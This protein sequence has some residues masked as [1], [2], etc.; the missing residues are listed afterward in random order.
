MF[1][2]VLM[3]G[4]TEVSQSFISQRRSPVDSGLRRSL[5]PHQ[6]RISSV[7]TGYDHP[8]ASSLNWRSLPTELSANVFARDQRVTPVPVLKLLLPLPQLFVRSRPGLT[9]ARAVIT[10]WVPVPVVPVCSGITPV[11][12]RHGTSWFRKWCGKLLPTAKTLR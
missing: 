8:S 6:W 3:N 2:H 11:V 4:T 7:F 9:Q 5:G 1:C 12:E 10:P